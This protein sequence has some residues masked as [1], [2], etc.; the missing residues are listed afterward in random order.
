MLDKVNDHDDGIICKTCLFIFRKVHD[1]LD[2]KYG[3]TFLLEI[4]KLFCQYIIGLERNVCQKAVDIYA[5]IITD[6][7]IERYLD[8]EYLCTNKLICEYNHYQLLNPDDYAREILKDKPNKK[9]PEISLN[10]TLKVLH[11][12]DVHTDT[13]YSEG[14]NGNCGKPLCCR[15]ENGPPKEA[16]FA[17]GRWGYQGFCDLPRITVYNF[18]EF[19][20][21]EIRPDFIL[22]TGDA[23]S[24]SVWDSTDHEAT[25]IVLF[26]TLLMKDKFNFTIPIYPA[27]GNHEFYP[28]DLFDPF[29]QTKNE[30]TLNITAELWRDW[31]GEDAYNTYIQ[32]GYYSKKHPDS[33]L[34]VISLNTMDCDTLNFNIVR[35]P[36]DP[37][38]QFK[39]LEGVLRQAEKDNE[40]IYIIGHIP[41]GDG[42][43]TS[44]CSK[45]YN[46]LVDRFQNIIRGQFFGHTH[47]DEFRTVHEYFNYSNV[48]GII[49]IAPSLTTYTSKNPQ[50]RV[51][52]ID[53]E[54]KVVIDYDQYF[55]NIT[56][57]NLNPDDTP[58]WEI[59]Y[60]A[61][62]AFKMNNMTDYS[63][64]INITQ[65][66]IVRIS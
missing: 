66:L 26:F 61:K 58:T 48:A 9:L 27:I 7:I 30:K 35:D 52:K 50:F 23:P 13:L 54:S 10:K 31:I 6:A 65:T 24:H 20:N 11:M 15:E 19:I 53:E 3:F 41:P 45:R 56:K 28:S 4:V 5:P 55:L 39:W 14:S 37:N 18:L 22:W 2:Q 51:L 64:F 60:N 62:D 21:E 17:A 33:N 42:S 12:S 32:R 63:K 47:Y 44:Q 57:A 36:S 46:A 49:H 40:V 16:K 59:L 29:N 1:F 38:K 25:D 8:A 34:R 43:Y